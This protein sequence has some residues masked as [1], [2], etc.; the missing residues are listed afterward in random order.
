MSGLDDLVDAQRLAET[1]PLFASPYPELLPKDH[2]FASK[3][4][5]V[6][7][8]GRELLSQLKQ[9]FGQ[10]GSPQE[11]FDLYRDTVERAY[12]QTPSADQPAVIKAFDDITTMRPE[13]PGS[14]S[15]QWLGDSG[16]RKNLS[17]E[18]RAVLDALTEYIEQPTT[19]L[20]Q[21]R[22]TRILHDIAAAPRPFD[23]QAPVFRG[24]R[25]YHPLVGYGKPGDIIGL[26]K[27]SSFSREASE[28]KKFTRSN[29]DGVVIVMV[30]RT[31]RQIQY[32]GHAL[33][34][35]DEFLTS[36]VA[37]VLGEY[38]DPWGKR[39][40]LS[41]HLDNAMDVDP[42]I[43]DV[44]AHAEQLLK[45]F[46]AKGGVIEPV[47]SKI[48]YEAPKAPAKVQLK[49]E[50][51]AR[52]MKKGNAP[53]LAQKSKFAKLEAAAAAEAAKKA[54]KAPP[55]PAES[56]PKPAAVAPKVLTEAENFKQQI[57]KQKNF[58][59]E[60]FALW[61]DMQIA[62]EEARKGGKR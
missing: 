30:P 6:L 33:L 41:A 23:A 44:K 18:Q 38:T 31:G 1:H 27:A 29:E 15:R 42:N 5:S 52:V 37:K 26:G 61:L 19:A 46:A 56:I 4:T 50:F 24:M 39:V 14:G 32:D 48:V 54:P 34:D 3:E 2:P 25:W 12:K 8:A 28:I 9:K 35:G 59:E 51:A 10:T 43:T 47:L 36:G 57:M 13:Q 49:D 62:K 58:T 17:P 22:S 7:P 45:L 53:N 60:E 16:E 20:Q 55:K 21:A 40:L 11:A